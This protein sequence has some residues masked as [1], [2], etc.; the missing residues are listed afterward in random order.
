ME[1]TMR[2]I[3]HLIENDRWVTANVDRVLQ[4]IGGGG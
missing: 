2:R 3:P 4:S 1:A